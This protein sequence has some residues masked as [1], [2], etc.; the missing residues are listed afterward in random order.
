M[1]E[2]QVDVNM[3]GFSKK[4]KNK[5]DPGEYLDPVD[6]Q[7]EGS[8]C[9]PGDNNPGGGGPDGGG[10]GGDDGDDGHGDG[11]DDEGG[12]DDHYP[13]PGHNPGFTLS[14]TVESKMDQ[15]LSMLSIQ[16]TEQDKV[17]SRVAKAERELKKYKE[18]TDCMEE[19]RKR[20]ENFGAESV[21]PIP[22]FYDGLFDPDKQRNKV[23]DHWHIIPSFD[24]V[25]RDVYKIGTFLKNCNNAQ[26]HCKMNQ[27][28]FLRQMRWRM[29]GT[30]TDRVDHWIANKHEISRIYFDL[31]AMYNV[32]IEATAAASVI[33]A[34][35]VSKTITFAAT[36]EELDRLAGIASQIIQNIKERKAVYDNYYKNAL[37]TRMPDTISPLIHEII[38][39]HRV[40]YNEEAT[41]DQIIKGLYRYTD[42][43]NKDF[44]TSKNYNYANRKLGVILD[45][46]YH[47]PMVAGKA[48]SNTTVNETKAIKASKG[49]NRGFKG[50][51]KVNAVNIEQPTFNRVNAGQSRGF[52]SSSN[53]S[54]NALNTTVGRAHPR[55]DIARI[56]KLEESRV[57]NGHNSA[58]NRKYCVFC[59]SYTHTGAEGCNSLYTDSLARAQATPTQQSCATCATKLHKELHHPSRLC[60]LRSTMLDAYKRGTIAPQGIFKYYL[61]KNTSNRA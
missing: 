25:K 32:E 57:K 33:T 59:S 13:E 49:Q 12:D 28:D 50:Q 10:D 56:L 26:E 15:L 9:P 20:K 18:K 44:H 23:K 61:A 16:N 42:K 7:S 45:K 31:Y 27:S 21:I 53:L 4:N 22:L 51:K 36:C 35:K 46:A 3:L 34:Y 24:P 1:S 5:G 37:I 58:K 41:S 30:V 43:I 38:A 47:K 17:N 54:V 55:L 52:T 60:P 19:I 8:E 14:G 29:T 2:T 11:G 6:V 40:N 39:D 48:D